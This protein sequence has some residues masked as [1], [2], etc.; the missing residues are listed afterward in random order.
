[1]IGTNV[2]KFT[3]RNIGFNKKED[4]SLTD[5]VSVSTID[6]LLEHLLNFKSEFYFIQENKYVFLDDEIPLLIGWIEYENNT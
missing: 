5:S 6:E 3:P 1:M 4:G 2:I